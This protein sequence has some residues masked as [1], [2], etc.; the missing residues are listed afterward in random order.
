MPAT[1]RTKRPPRRLPLKIS[2]DEPGRVRVGHLLEL[3]S[4]SHAT[5]YRRVAQ[6]IYPKPDGY[7]GKRPYWR[8][9]TV[10]EL[11]SR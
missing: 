11:L 7:D 6:G 3:L 10:K 2:L 9:D 5:F 4:T 8:T 1:I